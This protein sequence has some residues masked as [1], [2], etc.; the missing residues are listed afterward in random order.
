VVDGT[1]HAYAAEGLGIDD[2]PRAQASAIAQFRDFI[3]PRSSTLPA[4]TLVAFLLNPSFDYSLSGTCFGAGFGS[5]ASVR[6]TVTVGGQF[7]WTY[8]DSECAADRMIPS[9]GPFVIS[10]RIDEELD[11]QLVLS[12][13]A[14]GA[15]FPGSVAPYPSLADASNTL[16][17]FFDPV[18]N[19]LGDFGYDTASG[20][21]YLSPA[22]VEPPSAVPEPGALLLL[23]TGIA[24]LVARRRRGRPSASSRPGPP[25]N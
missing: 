10:G 2:I 7:D 21:S 22:A 5:S 3:T 4:G 24:G 16:R 15:G 6:A 14:W 11:V 20:N 8:Q 12:A 17:F 23:G 19:P 1:L 18:A 25:L 13:A 9:P